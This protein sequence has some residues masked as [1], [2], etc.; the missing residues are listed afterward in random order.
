MKVAVEHVLE[1]SPKRGPQPMPFEPGDAGSLD[2]LTAPSDLQESAREVR[3]PP[4]TLVFL[5]GDEAGSVFQVTKGIVMLYKLLPDGRRQVVELLGAGDVFG[6]SSLPV[7]DCFAETLVSTRCTVFQREAIERSPALM[8]R[9]SSRLY[10]Q[11]CDLHEHT[12][13]LG[14][15]SAM[16]RMTSFLMRCI[17]GRGGPRLSR[18]G[19]QR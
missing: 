17:P 14:R 16:E 3:F 6:F 5:E 1:G 2:A 10:R 9:L 11:L 19:R 4:R 12:M 15:K 18:A 8:R 7:H 13:L